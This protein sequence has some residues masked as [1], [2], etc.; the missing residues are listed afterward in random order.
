M[1]RILEEEQRQ[2]TE[3]TFATFKGT[4]IVNLQSSK[5]TGKGEMQ[6][7]IL[8]RF[9]SLNDNYLYN[10]FGL[11]TAKIRLILDYSP[12]A[13]LNVG[14]GY[15]S[16]FPRTYDGFAKY[17]IMR[18]S[19]GSFHF[20][21]SIIG[22]SS[23]FYS[24]ERF[25]DNSLLYNEK[26]RLNYVNQL[27]VAR[28]FSSDFSVEIVPAITHFNL[29]DSISDDND[30]FTLGVAMRYR[31][32]HQHAISI[33]FIHPL[34]S[35]SFL[36]LVEGKEKNYY[37]T[38]SIGYDIETGGHVFQL[39]LTNSRAVAEPFIFAQTPGN[40]INGDIHFGFNISRTFS[41][42]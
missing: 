40:W 26:H 38:L 41:I 18:Q 21:V 20:P 29:V 10:F 3:Y 14:L 34:N 15:A 22:Y 4:R 25:S 42:H 8:H 30:I 35:N 6:F 11:N 33:E 2:E 23:I 16:G 17:R 19:K 32:T 37:G 24:S 27:V 31:L 12:L 36:D 13:W 28:K 39:F 9:G 5:L 1:L 7:L